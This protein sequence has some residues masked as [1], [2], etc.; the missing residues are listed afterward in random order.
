VRAILWHQG[1]SDTYL[2]TSQADYTRDLS[3]VVKKLELDTSIKTPWIVANASYFP[4][5]ERD[6]SA[7]APLNTLVQ[8]GWS[9]LSVRLAQQSLWANG[10]VKKGPDT[11]GYIY[12]SYRYPGPN[13]SCVHFSDLGLKVHGGLWFTALSEAGL[14]PNL[15]TASSQSQTKPLYRYSSGA[16][17]LLSLKYLPDNPPAGYKFDGQAMSVFSNS[18]ATTLPL[19]PCRLRIG[20]YSHFVSTDPKCEGQLADEEGSIGYI[21][22]E[23]SPGLKPLFRF[24]SSR[25]DILSTTN[26]NEGLAAQ[27]VLQAWPLGYVLP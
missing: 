25:G 4:G 9:M 1:E 11:D 3:N 17:H 7:C 16:D 24:N 26:L 5:T 2:K 22:R 27:Y 14:V 20:V 23:I 18:S 12:S 6:D 15:A 19:Y 13:G 21:Q 10:L 8:N